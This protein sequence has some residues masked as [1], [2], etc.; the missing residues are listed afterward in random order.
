M[1]GKE[2]LPLLNFIAQG[3]QPPFNSNWSIPSCFP[4]YLNLILPGPLFQKSINDC[5]GDI[6]NPL[7]VLAQIFPLLS[8]IKQ[9]V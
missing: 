6:N 8:S 3:L 2:K 5:P 4:K 9:W 1:P 7:L